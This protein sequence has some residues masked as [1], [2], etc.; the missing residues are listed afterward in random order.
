MSERVIELTAK[1]LAGLQVPLSLNGGLLGAAGEPLIELRSELGLFGWPDA[2]ETQ[3]AL[4][5]KLADERQVKTH[6]VHVTA[7]PVAEDVVWCEECEEWVT[8]G[9]PEPECGDWPAPCNHD[10]AHLRGER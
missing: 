3:G 8:A 4:E 6:V 1:V 7:E 5:R 2:E 10:P 9:P